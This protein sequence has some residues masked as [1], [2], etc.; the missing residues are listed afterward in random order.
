MED[1]DLQQTG[2]AIIDARD[3]WAD[4]ARRHLKAELQRARITQEELARRLTA[5]GLAETAG[6]IAM[7]ISRGRYPAWFLFAVMRAIGS[8][9]VS[10]KERAEPPIKAA[11]CTMF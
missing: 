9:E 8:E 6:S 10:L 11:A 1:D 2:Q 5:M 4:Y 3:A 7:K